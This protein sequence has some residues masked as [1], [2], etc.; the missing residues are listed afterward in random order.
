MNRLQIEDI[1]KL[2][3]TLK[4][5]D[6]ADIKVRKDAQDIW[7]EADWLQEVLESSIVV[8]DM[9]EESLKHHTLSKENSMEIK[10]K[11]LPAIPLPLYTTKGLAFWKR[12][13]EKNWR[14]Q[15]ECGRIFDTTED[16]YA[17]IIYK[18][19]LYGELS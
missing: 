3:E 19:S 17:H 9:Q 4:G 10:G 7:F 14:P 16:Y 2:L 8:W 13:N 6:E 11:W 5:S 12:F 18:N 1:H 15:C